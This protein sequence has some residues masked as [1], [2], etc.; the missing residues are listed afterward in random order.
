MSA[1]RDLLAHPLTRGLDIDAPATTEVRRRIVR[2]KAF[3]RRLYEEWYR[4]VRSELPPVGGPVLELGSGA[5]FMDEFVEGLITSE[6]FRTPGASMVL[7][8]TRLPFA[9][10]SLRA[11]AMTDVFHHIPA[12]RSFLT[13]AVRCLKPGGRI[14]MVE[15]WVTGWSRFVY[16]RFHH[17]PFLTEA[18][19]WEFP[20][21]GPLSGANGALPWIV[22]ERDRPVFEREFPALRLRLL[23]PLMPMSYLASGGVT[24][25]S[26]MPG[27]AYAIVRALEK[28]GGELQSVAAMFALVVVEKP[29]STDA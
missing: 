17:E 13:E 18:E 19:H 24:M 16:T 12:V 6:I 25:R 8:G 28:F 3:L 21:S 9:S 27:A 5:G 10:A 4:L 7:D 23:R 29:D 11:I 14:V 22:F 15:P 26:L 20:S 2:E 1:L